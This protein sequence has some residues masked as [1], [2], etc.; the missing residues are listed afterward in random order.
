MWEIRIR[1][2]SDRV[3]WL[4]ESKLDLLLQNRG[5]LRA[6]VSTLHLR[7]EVHRIHD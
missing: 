4:Q 3:A 6:N 7:Q 5:S 1:K 2:R